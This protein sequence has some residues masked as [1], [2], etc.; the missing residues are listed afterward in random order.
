MPTAKKNGVNPNER[1]V[2]L[3]ALFPVVDPEAQ[4][5]IIHHMGANCY[6]AVAIGPARETQ[7]ARCV[8]ACGDQLVEKVT[9]DSDD[10]PD[11]PAPVLVITIGGKEPR[12]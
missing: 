10:W 12:E 8:E 6:E 1:K 5:L 4:V 7:V 2:A 3:S 11:T 9:V